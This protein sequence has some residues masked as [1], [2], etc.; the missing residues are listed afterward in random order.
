MHAVAIMQH[1][2]LAIQVGVRQV[3]PAYTVAFSADGTE[4]LTGFKDMVRIFNVDRPGRWCQKRSTT[5]GEPGSLCSCCI[6]VVCPVTALTAT[7][8]ASIT[9]C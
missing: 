7:L 1:Q 3:A 2:A 5:T 9:V 8:L 4:L 6:G